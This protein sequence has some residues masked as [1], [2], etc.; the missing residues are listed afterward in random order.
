MILENII[1][2]LTET[3]KSLTLALCRASGGA[4]GVA[5]ASEVESGRSGDARLRLELAKVL[6]RKPREIAGAAGGG[7]AASGAGGD[8]VVE[9]AGVPEFP[10]RPRAHSRPS[11][12][13]V[14]DGAAPASASA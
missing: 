2:Q 14:C 1:E 11:I 5:D 8:G 12:F 13:A 4:G 7:D 9:G 6:M 10:L 3:L